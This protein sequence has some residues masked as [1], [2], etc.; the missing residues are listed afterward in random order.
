MFICGLIFFVFIFPR[1]GR[2]R[3]GGRSAADGT[4]VFSIGQESR[5]FADKPR[6][7]TSRRRRRGGRLHEFKEG[8]D[9]RE[10]E[11][12]AVDAVEEAA[13]AG[14]EAAAVFDVRAALHSGF[15]EVAELAGDIGG[16]GER[17]GLPPGDT[18]EKSVEVEATEQSGSDDGGDGTFPGFVRADLG[19]EFVFTETAADVVGADIAHPVEREAEHQPVGIEFAQNA[20]ALP[21]TEDIEDAG[22]E[23]GG[24]GLSFWRWFA[25]FHRIPSV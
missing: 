25:P 21:A 19:G 8:V 11:E 9:Y 18:G 12:G 15:G 4:A 2:P 17:D 5:K 16:G 10:G 14:E 20:R 7:C 3:G 24:A 6:T 1:Y 22:D 13:V 23:E